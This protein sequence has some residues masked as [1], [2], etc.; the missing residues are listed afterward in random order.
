LKAQYTG[1]RAAKF[2]PERF[3]GNVNHG[4]YRKIRLDR[5]YQL[6][7][8]HARHFDVRY[9][10]V[11]GAMKSLKNRKGILSVRGL[12]DVKTSQAQYRRHIGSQRL[13]V[14]HQ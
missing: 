10:N 12:E 6:E 3:P 11:Y 2:L 1:A 5:R 9:E 13:F 4:H 14:I 8:S 7:T